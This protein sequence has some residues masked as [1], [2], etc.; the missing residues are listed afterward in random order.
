M[1]NRDSVELVLPATSANLG[2]AF[3]AAALAFNLF[4]R[5]KARAAQRILDQAQRDETRTFAAT[6]RIISFLQLIAKFWKAKEDQYSRFRFASTMT[7]RLAKAVDRLRRRVLRELRWPSISENC[8]GRKAES[9]EKH[10]AASIM[11]TMPP[12]AGSVDLTVARMAGDGEAQTVRIL[13]KGKW[14]LLLAVPEES[15]S[16]EEARRVLPATYSRADVVS[17]IQNSMFLLAALT[18]GQPQLMATALED[19]MHQPYRSALCPL[20]PALT[21]ARSVPSGILGV[22]L[23]G[24]GPSVLIFVDPKASITEVKDSGEESSSRGWTF[25]GID[26]HLDHRTRR[27]FVLPFSSQKEKDRKST[28]L[29]RSNFLAELLSARRWNDAIH[30]QIF[31]HLTIVIKTD[32]RW[33][34]L[35]VQA[36]CLA[37]SKG[38]LDVVGQILI[39]K[40]VHSF[41]QIGKG[42]FQELHDVG[43]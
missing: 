17:N 11:P 41:V 18:Q 10:L 22:A 23:S 1:N 36:W 9:S 4:L 29:F 42:I 43:F 37:F 40:R 8:A 13:P 26:F 19:R 15:L 24:A 3:D 31:H 34:W 32:E 38:A 2:P 16:T 20:L 33:R 6:S 7:F 39:G 30:S 12:R 14:P 25:R 5:V 21:K 28:G 27:Q 35:P